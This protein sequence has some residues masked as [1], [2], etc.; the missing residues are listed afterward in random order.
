MFELLGAQPV[1]GRVFWPEE[2]TPDKPL[3]VILSYG[4]WQRRFGGDLKRDRPDDHNQWSQPHH[5]GSNAAGFS[6]GYEVMP[7][8]G[9]V[10]QAEMLLPLPMGV[11]HL[12]NHDDE[13]Y[14]LLARLKQGV[15][16]AQAQTEL[17]L[18]ARRLEQQHPESYPANRRFRYS[19]KPLLEQV[20][21]DVRCRCSCF[22]AQSV[23][24]C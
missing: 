15:T 10:A 11:K 3:T 20:V 13:N 19:V 22:S 17:D 6:L 12:D 2:D 9:S 21:G 1:L 8:V 5:R 4:L 16:I 23:A 24:C 14:N 18:V 7:T